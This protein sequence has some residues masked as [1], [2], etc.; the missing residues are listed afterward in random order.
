M[1]R[2]FRAKAVFVFK[3]VARRIRWLPHDLVRRLRRHPDE[4]EP[5][6]GLAFV[7]HGDFRAV[8]D[9]YATQFE[10]LGGMSSES[11]VL[12]IGCGIGRMAIPLTSRLE[13]GSYEGF[14]T[15][16]AMIRWCT[17]NIS[18]RSPN[19]SFTYAPVYNQ[20]YNPFGSIEASEFEFP[21]GDEEF[22]FAFATS[23]FTHLSIEDS[24]RYLTE[25]ARVL[26]PGG[27]ALLTLFILDGEG[28]KPMDDDLAYCF[29]FGFGPLWST[30]PKEPEAAVA[31]PIDV[32]EREVER[33]GLSFR[34]PVRWGRWP[35]EE[36]GHDVQDIIV[37]EKTEGPASIG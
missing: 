5:P 36:V 37:L 29:S 7:G 6:A 24:R 33:A 34:G 11:R 16:E 2:N 35:E 8:G 22:D 13:S 32:L 25:L 28:R 21:Y 26:V 15:S 23:V 9:W 27:T 10:D 31:F 20:K 4:L 17:R 3:A 18:T 12:D 14:D 30:N 1:F 19:F